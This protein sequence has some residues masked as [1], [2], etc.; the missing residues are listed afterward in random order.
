MLSSNPAAG[1]HWRLSG[2]PDSF[3][4]DLLAGCCLASGAVTT[5]KLIAVQLTHQAELGL[6]CILHTV[7]SGCV[8]KFTVRRETSEEFSPA[9]QHCCT[10]QP[11]AWQFNTN[12]G[13]QWLSSSMRSADAAAGVFFQVCMCLFSECA[14]VCSSVSACHC[15]RE[16]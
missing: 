6:V 10:R 13:T 15:L 8:L 12:G 16:C 1:I 7:K 2:G 14:A 9:V 4:L 11:C 5:L 3:S